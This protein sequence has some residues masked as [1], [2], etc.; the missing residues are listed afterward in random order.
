MSHIA[1]DRVNAK[2]NLGCSY[3]DKHGHIENSCYDKQC[4]EQ[5]KERAQDTRELP[6]QVFKSDAPKK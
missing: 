4:D 3:C 5:Y 6:I 2:C 1:I